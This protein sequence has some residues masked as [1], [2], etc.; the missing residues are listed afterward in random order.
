LRAVDFSGC[1][2][3]RLRRFDQTLRAHQPDDAVGRERWQ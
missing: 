3:R 2:Q 1:R